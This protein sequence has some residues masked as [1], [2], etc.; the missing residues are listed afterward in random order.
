M[1]CDSPVVESV[2]PAG[3]DEGCEILGGTVVKDHEPREH[4]VDSAISD[5]EGLAAIRNGSIATISGSVIENNSNHWHNGGGIDNWGT[6]TIESSVIRNNDAA[7]LGGGI[8]NSDR[9]TLVDGEVTGNSA[10]DGGGI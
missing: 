10:S 2:E 8:Y 1:D 9:L 7:G 5:I 4:L 6:L 3:F